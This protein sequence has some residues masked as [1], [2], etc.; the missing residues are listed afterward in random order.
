VN[1]C[2][3]VCRITGGG[4]LNEKGGNSGHKQNTFG[5]NVSP[6]H[7]GGGPTGNEWE[8][9]IRQG[10]TILFNFHSHDAHIT[11]CTVVPP[12]P[13]HPPAINTRADFE[14]TGLYSFGPG[15]RSQP[16]NFSAYIID[17]GEGKCGAR[18]YYTITVRSGLL[19]GQ[20]TVVFSIAGTSDCGNLQVHETPASIFG[21]IGNPVPELGT[22]DPGSNSGTDPRDGAAILNRVIP[23]PFSGTMSYSYRVPEGGEQSVDVSIYDMA[24]RRVRSLASGAQSP[25]QYTVQWDGRSDLG[26]QMA[27]GAYFLRARVA[28]AQQ[29]TRV[30]YLKQ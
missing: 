12:G 9:V 27:P 24:G 17:H 18:D 8:H 30:I 16:A 11:A 10:S 26:V 25:G 13:C 20:G 15:T 29:V 7:T 2:G 19:Q 4:C 14:G 21:P 3:D 28:G 5:G 22:E 6:L 1:P 23:N